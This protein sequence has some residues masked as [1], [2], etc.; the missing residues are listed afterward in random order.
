[1][2]LVRARKLVPEKELAR[3]LDV[4]TLTGQKS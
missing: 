2:D 4:R 1:V 3:L